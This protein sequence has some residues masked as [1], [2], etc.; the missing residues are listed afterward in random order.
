[1]QRR[2]TGKR[3]GAKPPVSVE[4]LLTAE[5]YAVMALDDTDEAELVTVTWPGT[6]G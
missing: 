6:N 2:S 3:T 5:D 4:S 1:M